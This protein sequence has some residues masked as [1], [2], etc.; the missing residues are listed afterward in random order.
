MRYL[1]FDVFDAEPGA[2]AD[3]TDALNRTLVTVES[4]PGVFGVDGPSMTPISTRAFFW[5]LMGRLAI[6]ACRTFLAARLGQYAPCWV[7]SYQSDLELT[8]DVASIDTAIEIRSVGYTIA[9]ATNLARQHV[10]FFVG[11]LI[12]PVK[13]IGAHDNGDGTETLTLESAPGVAIPKGTAASFLLFSRLASDDA[14]IIYQTPAYA[15]C[16]LSFVEVPREVPA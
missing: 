4:A 7:P 1:G 8:L 13:V 15:E 9:Y 12:V 3:A 11:G 5:Q 14:E 10:A 6:T 16:T 2:V